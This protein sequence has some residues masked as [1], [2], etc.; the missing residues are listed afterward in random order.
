MA[1]MQHESPVRP[2]EIDPESPWAH[3]AEAIA[4]ATRA[5]AELGYSDA[6][7]FRGAQGEAFEGYMAQEAQEFGTK[8]P[9]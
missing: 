1:Q 4:A 8:S 2:L 3:D 5:N 7:D 6:F 9:A